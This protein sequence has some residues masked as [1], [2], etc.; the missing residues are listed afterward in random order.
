MA[1]LTIL[2]INV[3]SSNLKASLFDPNGHRKDFT[4]PFRNKTEALSLAS[5]LIRLTDALHGCKPDVIS[6]RFVHG[7]DITDAARRIDTTEGNRLESISHLAPLHMPKSLEGVDYCAKIFNVPQVAC[8]DTAFH[9]TLPEIAYR[10]PIPQHL[11]IRRYGFHGLNYAYITKQ[12]PK[13]L[14]TKATGHIIIAHLGSGASL[15][16]LDHLKSVDTTMGYTP[17]GG[18][19]MATRSG[20]IDPGVML[21]LAKQFS[22]EAL[23]KLTFEQMGLFALSD[24]KSTDVAILEN[25]N[26]DSAQFALAYFARQIRAQIGALAAKAGGIDA[27]VFTGG[28][29]EHSALIRSLVCKE[30][31]FLNLKLD[32]A[33]NQIHATALHQPDTKPILIIP[34]NEESE[35]AALT[36]QIFYA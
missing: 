17:A 27:L 3:G 1:L 2:T 16:L 25:D 30:L 23:T 19:P 32:T 31:A 33:A 18:I 24:Q 13:H 9:T 21:A 4:F 10:L 35:M 22:P 29:G 14:G 36:Q 28:I 26:S 7:G 5:V 12:L 34:A 6:H 11:N 8:F 20:D 15:C